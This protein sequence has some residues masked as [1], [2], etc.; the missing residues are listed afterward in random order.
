MLLETPRLIRELSELN[1]PA[2]DIVGKHVVRVA[3]RMAR[4]VA[5]HDDEGQV[6]EHHPAAMAAR[7][8]RGRD[9]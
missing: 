4:W 3:T 6:S 9:L 8:R 2:A 1:P 5:R 7:Q